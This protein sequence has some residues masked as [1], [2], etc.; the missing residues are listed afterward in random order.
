MAGEEKLCKALTR[1]YAHSACIPR[2]VIQTSFTPNG[3]IS[4]IFGNVTEDD[5]L[6][7][8]ELEEMA[9]KHKR[10]KVSGAGCTCGGL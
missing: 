8:K 4:L 6:L 5:I 2:L 1:R 10:F 3:Q 7:Q 9:S